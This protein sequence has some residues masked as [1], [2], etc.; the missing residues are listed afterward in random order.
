MGRLVI[1]TLAL[2]GVAALVTRADDGSATRTAARRSVAVRDKA[3]PAWTPFGLGARFR[4]S[5]RSAPRRLGAW[6]CTRV[7]VPRYGAHIEL[8]AAGRVVVVPAGIGVRAARR[9]GAYV[10][11]GSCALPMRTVEPTGVVEVT[12]GTQATLGRL[13]ALW[14]A[15]LSRRGFAGFRGRV[16]VWVNGR[17]H[18]GDPRGLALGEHD[19]VVVAVGP[20]VPVHRTFTFREGL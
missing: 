13:F 17:R 19:Q 7:A 10:T 1:V 3:L 8:F 18:T 5:A 16:R 9:T 14:G 15:D 20:R 11:G 6:T 2:L 12:R 4:P